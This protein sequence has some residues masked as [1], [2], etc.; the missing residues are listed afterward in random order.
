[1]MPVRSR[2]GCC[3]CTPHSTRVPPLGSVRRTHSQSRKNSISQE[4]TGGM[5]EMLVTSGE[6]GVDCDRDSLSVRDMPAGRLPT[7]LPMKLA[8]SEG[9]PSLSHLRPSSCAAQAHWTQPQYRSDMHGHPAGVVCATLLHDPGSLLHLQVP[10]RLRS[11]KAAGRRYSN[12]QGSLLGLGPASRLGQ[13]GQVLTRD[14][15]WAAYVP[16]RL[17]SIDPRR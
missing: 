5:L 6:A 14:P 17:V 12:R 1:M 7:W 11:S 8:A 13:A 15:R 9:E 4:R 3:A 2:R 10:P 16:A